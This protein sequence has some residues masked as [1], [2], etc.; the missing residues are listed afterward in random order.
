MKTRLPLLVVSLALI[1][2]AGC[3]TPKEKTASEKPKDEYVY[4]TPTGSN[5]PVRV[6][7]SDVQTT[8]ADTQAIQDA[9]RTLQSRGSSE[10]HGN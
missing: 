7:K 9:L 1:L 2:N 8:D 6:K 4:Y 5:I 3:T 10:H